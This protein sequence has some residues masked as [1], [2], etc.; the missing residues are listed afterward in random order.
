[1]SEVTLEIEDD[2][3]FLITGEETIEKEVKP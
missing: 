1:M 2:D 3:L